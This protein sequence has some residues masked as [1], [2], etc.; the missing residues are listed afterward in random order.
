M[1]NIEVAMKRREL[2]MAG[3][4]VT[5]RS[6]PNVLTGAGVIAGSGVCV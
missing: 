3:M 6:Q 1:R 5:E 2:E 4:I